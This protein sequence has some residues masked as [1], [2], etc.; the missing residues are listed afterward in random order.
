MYGG[1]ADGGAANFY[2]RL[3][4]MVREPD[5]MCQVVT[6]ANFHNADYT[7]TGMDDD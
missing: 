2:A 3:W 5:P 7:A 4:R 1:G 6:G